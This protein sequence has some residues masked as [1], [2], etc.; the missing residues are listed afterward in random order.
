MVHVATITLGKI[1]EKIALKGFNFSKTSRF[2][3]A[4]VLKISSVN[5]FS[6]VFLECIFSRTA[7]LKSDRGDLLERCSE[8]WGYSQE[9]IFVVM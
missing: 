1:T 2:Y 5:I 3:S 7:L 9:N 8:G 4:T 6:R